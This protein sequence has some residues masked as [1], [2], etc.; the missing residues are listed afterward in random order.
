MDWHTPDLKLFDMGS[1]SRSG[2]GSDTAL[3]NIVM[4]GDKY[5]TEIAIE[6]GV[7]YRY[8][9]GDTGNRRGYG[10]P[11][12]AGEFDLGHSLDILLEDS[13]RR[14]VPMELCLFDEDQKA[15]VDELA[16]VI[17]DT[18]IDDNDYIYYRERLATL[19]G[20]KLQKKRNHLNH[21]R[22]TYPDFTY[23]EINDS[24]KDDA[25]Y[26]ASKWLEERPEQS[27]A[28]ILEYESIKR[29]LDNREKMKMFGGILYVAEKPAAMTYA[30]AVS[31]RCVDVHFEKAIGEYA[32]N[33]AFAAINNC[34]ASSEAVSSYEYFNREEDMGVEGLRRAK[35][36]Y[37]PVIRLK[38]FYGEIKV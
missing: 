29:A 25:L 24:N 10:F 5:D 15:A 1:F 26:V 16:R 19:S 31:P 6:D 2:M 33:G 4:L 30:S 20:R 36:T 23:S 8:Y 35:E 17:W 21:F 34:F 13:E 27:E 12:S 11:L 32:V 37:D 7:L 38:K 28:E 9:Q 3:A 14:G 18:T 22:N